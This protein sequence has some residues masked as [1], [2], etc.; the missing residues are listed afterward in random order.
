MY[1]ST[2]EE[3]LAL[4]LSKLTLA[5]AVPELGLRCF[6]K[7]KSNVMCVLFVLPCA[8]MCTSD[9]FLLFQRS[10][11]L[12]QQINTQHGVMKRFKHFIWANSSV[13]NGS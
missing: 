3:E 10:L 11:Q 7:S 5:I 13:K 8:P 4:Y 2:T 9:D 1:P 6:G 12:D